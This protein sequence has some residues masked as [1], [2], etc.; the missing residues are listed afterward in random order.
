M[1]IDPRTMKT[2]LTQQLS[3][4]PSYF[5]KGQTKHPSATDDSSAVFHTVLSAQLGGTEA[6]PPGGEAALPPR[7]WA[8]VAEL[9]GAASSAPAASV[10][11]EAASGDRSSF[12]GLI[13][14]AASKYGIDPSLVHAVIRTESNYDPNAQSGAGAKGLMQLMDA[15][16]RSLGVTDSF[17]P[18]QN[19]DAGT[20]YLSFLLRK[21]NGHEAV[22]LA[23][24]NAGP[25]RI[26]RLGISTT[27]ELQA[28][29]QELPE[30][31]RNYIA[32]VAAART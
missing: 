3:P 9:I 16:A 21:Y 7:L 2:L 23:A 18:A 8:S 17:D 24:Y 12:A 27:E 26:D 19:I 28:R 30:E 32:K 14:L 4:N 31:T 13:G 6:L 1:G 22:A 15:T 20:R 5:I 29:L 10:G 25:G 11:G